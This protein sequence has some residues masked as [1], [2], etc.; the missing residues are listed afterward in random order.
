MKK[1]ISIS[2]FAILMVLP[3]SLLLYPNIGLI[4]SYEGIDIRISDILSQGKGIIITTTQ[5]EYLGVKQAGA[6]AIDINNDFI[7]DL[8]IGG[9]VMRIF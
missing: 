8:F 7:D 5:Q 9:N 4:Q 1:K 3:S 2:C 6:H